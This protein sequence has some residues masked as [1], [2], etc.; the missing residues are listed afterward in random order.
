MRMKIFDKKILKN[1]KFVLILLSIVVIGGVA[2]SVVQVVN[3]LPGNATTGSAPNPGHS[4]N[5][6]ANFSC[7]TGECL[8]SNSSGVLVCAACGGGTNYWTQSGTALFPSQTTWN[9]GIGTTNPS[10]KLD[11]V[12]VVKARTSLDLTDSTGGIVDY[13]GSSGSSGQMLYRQTNGIIWGNKPSSTFSSMTCQ[14]VI[15]STITVNDTYAVTVNCPS[16]YEVIRCE[17]TG[18]G[19]RDIYPI[20]LYSYTDTNQCVFNFIDPG[21][22]SG[23]VIPY[24]YCCQ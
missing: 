4:W 9:V 7:P 3:A 23:Q 20:T 17:W 24:A 13:Y 12:G 10:A 21:V 22:G 5:Q 1:K 2:F 11:V 8:Q 19:S 15:G 14:R 6:I 16:G 18:I